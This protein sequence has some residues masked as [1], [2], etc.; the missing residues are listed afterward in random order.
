MTIHGP[1]E[2]LILQPTPFCNLNCDYCYLPNRD[3]R[4]IM[5]IATVDEVAR[6]VFSTD[7]PA[8]QLSVVWHAGEPLTVPRDWYTEAV[9][10]IERHRRPRVRVVHHVQTNGVLIDE[11]WCRLFACHA[12]QIG[13]SLDGPAWLH[14]RH[15]KARG[16]QGTHAGVMRGVARLRSAGLSF[17]AICVLTRESL[18]NADAIYDFFAETGVTHVGFNIEEKEAAHDHSSLEAPDSETAFRTF[19][20]RL[21]ERLRARPAFRV[22]EVENVLAALRHPWF[23]RLSGNSQ[24]EPGR[25]IT[26]ACDGT[27][28]T[29]SPELVGISWAHGR[30]VALGNVLADDIAATLRSSTLGDLASTIAAGVRRCRSECKYFDFCLG[31]APANKLA[32][33]G[34]FAATETMFCRLTQQAVVDTVLTLLD[35]DLAESAPRAVYPRVP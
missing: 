28:A 2:L 4:R 26:V 25:I 17:H 34:S 1:L 33:T 3:E 5:D 8:P 27:F 35:R 21:M 31:G 7:L 32:E 24:N 16:G 30:S 19:F 23:G 29:Y 14:D 13:V 11:S 10:R 20:A 6:Q 9:A 15:R 22:R 18:A 12:M